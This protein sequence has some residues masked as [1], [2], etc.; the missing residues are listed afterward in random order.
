MIFF[1]DL[2]VEA[3][4]IGAPA[5]L[6][7]GEEVLGMLH[8][9]GDAGGGAGGDDVS[10]LQGHELRDIGDEVGYGHDEI[11]CVA[12]LSGYAIDGEVQGEVVDVRGFVLGDEAGTQGSE[13]VVAFA[14]RPLTAVMELPVA[15]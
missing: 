10:G 3:K 7:A 13:A 9:H 5:D 11:A 6:V 14:L 1:D 2:S 4:E 15:F 8:A 12:V